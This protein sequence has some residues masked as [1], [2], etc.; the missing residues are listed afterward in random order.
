MELD[1]EFA[2]FNH[3]R[4]AASTAAEQAFASAD[5]QAATLLY[6]LVAADAQHALD[7]IEFAALAHPTGQL[8]G[9]RSDLRPALLA[10]RYIANAQLAVLASEF[11][12]AVACLRT[13][14]SE[15]TRLLGLDG[16]VDPSANACVRDLRVATQSIRA[17]FDARQTLSEQRE[18]LSYG[19]PSRPD[20][21]TN[22]PLS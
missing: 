9:A 10:H 21:P 11:E 16:E 13:G 8:A 14:I 2:Q 18:T 6:R 1:R 3:R 19:P 15:V 22:G 4:K 12:G 17:K 7:V 20:A 5:T